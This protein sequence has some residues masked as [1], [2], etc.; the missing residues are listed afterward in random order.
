[1]RSPLRPAC[2]RALLRSPRRLRGNTP[3]RRSQG[4]DGGSPSSHGLGPR[5]AVLL[6]NPPFLFGPDDYNASHPSAPKRVP[7][8]L[9]P[10]RP[11]GSR[12]PREARPGR[13]CASR[14]SCRSASCKA[15]QPL[16]HSREAGKTCWFLQPRH[17]YRRLG[18][19]KSELEVYRESSATEPAT[20]ALRHSN[21]LCALAQSARS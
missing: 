20:V 17:L 13:R 18:S 3:P 12:L 4:L 5:Q 2:P 11:S 21:F 8:P 15:W 16:T 14:A 10:T 9:T 19:A 6:A 1:M 7:S